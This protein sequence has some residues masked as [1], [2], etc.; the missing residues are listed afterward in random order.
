[1]NENEIL[2][3]ILEEAKNII[4]KNKTYDFPNLIPEN[5]NILIEKIDKNKSLISAIVSS[6]L[7]KIIN[8]EQDVRLH[9]TDFKGG[10][11]ARSLD[12]RFTAPFF[13][14]IFLSMQI[15][16]QHF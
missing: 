1:M 10:Y 7:K 11:S 15:K 12:T 6:L 8:P 9:R 2:E 3:K 5:I 16:N 14:N 13:K 4:L